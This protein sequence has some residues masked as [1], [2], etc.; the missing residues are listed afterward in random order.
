[1]KHAPIRHRLEQA[2]YLGIRGLLRALPHAAARGVGRRLGGLAAILDRRHLRVA[3][4]NL[5]L[6]FPD[7]SAAERRAHARECFRHFGGAVCDLISADRFDLVELCRRITY[8]G[9]EH[10]EAAESAGK[11][12]F[13]LGSHLGYWELSGRPIGLYRGT[14]HAVARPADNPHFEREIRRLRERFAY[15]VIP[16]KGAARRMIQILRGGG[17]VGILIDQR[18]QPREAIAVPFFGRP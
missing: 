18:V 15:A 8:E 5:A 10:V 17:R 1:M 9:W 3:E 12:V 16:K 2:A 14:V 7:L 11:G 6:A 4:K 13:V